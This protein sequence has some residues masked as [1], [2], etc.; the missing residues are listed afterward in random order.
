[1]AFISD[2]FSS[3]PLVCT[4]LLACSDIFKVKKAKTQLTP[5]ILETLAYL[6]NGLKSHGVIL[7]MYGRLQGLQN[8]Q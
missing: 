8:G 7:Q 4:V 2:D 3:T 1:L 5:G 6:L